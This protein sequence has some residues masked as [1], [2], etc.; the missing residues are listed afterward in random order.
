MSAWSRAPGGST[1]RTTRAAARAMPRS[2]ARARLP[3]IDGWGKGARDPAAVG[4]HALQ[5][6]GAVFAEVKVDPDLGQI[7]VT[8]LVGAFAAGRIINPRLVR[9]QLYG[10]MIWGVSF[11]LHEEASTDRRSGRIMNAD[12]GEY[13]VALNADVPSLEALLVPRGRRLRQRA[14]HQGRR[15]DQHYRDGRRHR[16]RRLARDRDESPQVSRED[17]GHHGARRRRLGRRFG[18]RRSGPLPAPCFGSSE[19]VGSLTPGPRRGFHDFNGLRRHF[20]ANDSREAAPASPSSRA[21]RKRHR[22]SPPA[23]MAPSRLVISVSF[24]TLSPTLPFASFRFLSSFFPSFCFLLFPSISRKRDLSRGYAGV[25]QKKIR[26]IFACPGR[27]ARSDDGGI[28]AG[29]KG[30]DKEGSPR[31]CRE[32]R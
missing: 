25:K 4:D 21:E 16:K 1:A 18:R 13:H 32:Q 2:S 15:R 22:S 26:S 5:A 3:E 10:G 23:W 12:L 14:R 31:G 9:S 30:P 11:A 29:S 24:R 6:H 28:A 8:R 20:R 19:A 27:P 7:R 17:R